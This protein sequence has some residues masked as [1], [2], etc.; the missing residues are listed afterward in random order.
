MQSPGDNGVNP[1]LD[2]GKTLLGYRVDSAR[3]R[4]SILNQYCCRSMLARG[5]CVARLNI[6]GSHEAAPNPVS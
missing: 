4:R 3:S 1:W 6:Q 2:L 5:K